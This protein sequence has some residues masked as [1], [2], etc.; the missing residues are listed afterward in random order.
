MSEPFLGEIRLFVFSYA[1]KGWAQ[2]NGQ[3]MQINQ[4][5]ALFALLGNTYGGDG[6]TTFALPDLRGRVP[7]HH[8]NGITLGERW[9]EEAHALTSA[10]MPVHSHQSRGGAA[11]STSRSPG[12]ALWGAEAALPYGTA[13]DSIMSPEAVT[14]AGGSQPHENRQ[15]YLVLNFC[16]ALSGIFPSQT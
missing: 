11:P 13:P 10:E 3:I 16:I 6:Q 12:G 2:C 9:G 4:N 1:P 8:G 15:P 7:V 5:Q 14:V